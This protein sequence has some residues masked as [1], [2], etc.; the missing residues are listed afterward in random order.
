[1]DGFAH[2]ISATYL[3]YG[4]PTSMG[5]LGKFEMLCDNYM[6]RT[7]KNWIL[8]AQRRG[9]KGASSLITRRTP[10]LRRGDGK[11]WRSEK[12][13]VATGRGRAI[14][15]IKSIGRRVICAIQGIKTTRRQ[16]G[17]GILTPKVNPS[18]Y[19]LRAKTGQHFISVLVL[20][21][22]RDELGCSEV[23]STGGVGPIRMLNWNLRD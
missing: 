13:P 8:I 21:T 23:L 3:C 6:M 17:S 16:G 2:S 7:A 20:G 5:P 12:S 1:M 9:V 10:I 14:K 19:W 4:S 22:Q 18:R 15:S 11:A